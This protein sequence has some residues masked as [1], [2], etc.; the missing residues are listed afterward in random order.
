MNCYSGISTAFYIS[1][2]YQRNFS[3]GYLWEVV[4]SRNRLKE[5]LKTLA[6]ADESVHN[7]PQDLVE[8]R[9]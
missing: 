4:G 2:W 8:E 7:N 6:M 1:Y 9:F 3:F 5:K